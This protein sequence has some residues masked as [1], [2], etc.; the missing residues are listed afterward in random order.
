M[1]TPDNIPDANNMEEIIRVQSYH[2][3]YIVIVRQD[4]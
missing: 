2:R 1:P 4:H 3:W